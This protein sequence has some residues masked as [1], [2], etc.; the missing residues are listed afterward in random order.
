MSVRQR[1]VGRR[2]TGMDERVTFDDVTDL[3]PRT[4]Y[5]YAVDARDNVSGR[6]GPRSTTVKARTRG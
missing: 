4:T 5:F 6:T 3:R 2:A 1:S